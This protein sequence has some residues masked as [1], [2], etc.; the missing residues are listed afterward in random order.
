MYVSTHSSQAQFIGTFQAWI[1]KNRFFFIRIELESFF[2]TSHVP[3]VLPFSC[4]HGTGRD[5]QVELGSQRGHLGRY[6]VVAVR[7]HQ[8]AHQR[9][10]ILPQTRCVFSRVVSAGTTGDSPVIYIDRKAFLQV[11]TYI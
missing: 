6:E 2:N 7:P 9:L 1:L 8:G 10:H 4:L 5:L 3:R 11:L